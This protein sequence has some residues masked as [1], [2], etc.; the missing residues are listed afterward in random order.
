MSNK[1]KPQRPQAALEK[2]SPKP[3]PA[4]LAEVPRSAAPKPEVT[5]EMPFGRM[6]YLLL[7]VGVALLAIGFYLMS[8][9]PFIDAT[10]FSISLHVAPVVVVIGFVEI[11]FAIMYRPKSSSTPGGA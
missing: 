8:L 7:L 11:I 10:Q 6:N 3:A 1:K 5:A 2:S 9:E 4:P